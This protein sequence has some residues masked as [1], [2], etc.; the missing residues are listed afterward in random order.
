MSHVL[1]TGHAVERA[2]QR[3]GLEH[4]YRETERELARQ[5]QSGARL[6]KRSNGT[7]DELRKV[8]IFGNTCVLLCRHDRAQR[9]LVV[10]TTLWDQAHPVQSFDPDGEEDPVP[11]PN[12]LRR[13]NHRALGYKGRP[14]L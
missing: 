14:S 7:R 6:R 10:I 9:K 1:V 11:P 4:G 2:Q 12:Y 8:Q 3:L 13:P 5:V